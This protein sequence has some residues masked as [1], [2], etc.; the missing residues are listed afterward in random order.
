VRGAEEVRHRELPAA[1]GQDGRRRTES[2]HGRH[3]FPPDLRGAGHEGR[4]PLRPGGD[5]GNQL[6]DGIVD[7]FCFGAG[8]PVPIFSQLDTE[9]EV[10]FFTWTDPD[11]TAIRSKIPEFS[12]STI[13]KRTYRQQTA[14]QKTIGLYNFA[15][16]HKDLPESMA[17]AITKTVLENN[18]RLVKG[19]TAA[20]ETIAANA[21]RNSFLPFHPGAVRYYNEKGVKLDP[22]T[23]PK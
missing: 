3:L 18:A 22:A 16:A 8:A 20:R 23:L 12:G 11:I 2:R 21:T 15:F 1:R 5:V 7:A 6:G 19:H 4:L 9:K 10:V 13:A 14:D 17:Y